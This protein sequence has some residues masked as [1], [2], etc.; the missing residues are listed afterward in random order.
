MGSEMCIRDSS[1]SVGVILV[2]LAQPT[3]DP[4]ARHQEIGHSLSNAKNQIESVPGD[5]I[6]QYSVILALTGEMIDKL[7]LSNRVPANGHTLISNL[8]GPPDPLYLKGAK[9][10]QMCPISILL[11]GLRMNI[12]LFSCSGILNFGIVATR[13]MDRL[14]ELANCIEDEF[15]GLKEALGI[16]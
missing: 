11:P 10:E 4:F 5:S 12:T 16:S 13:D 6:E 7:H 14:D 2:E 15:A 8:P 1:N 9:V 3:E